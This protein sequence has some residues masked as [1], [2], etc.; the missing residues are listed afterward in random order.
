MPHRHHRNVIDLVSSRETAERTKAQLARYGR[1]RVEGRPHL[2]VDYRHLHLKHAI[3]LTVIDRAH[4]NTNRRRGP[5][6]GFWRLMA[7]LRG[8]LTGAAP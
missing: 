7:S 2:T 3:D 4:A 6:E 5:V 8:L 1:D